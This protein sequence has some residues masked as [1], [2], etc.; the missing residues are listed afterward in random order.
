MSPDKRPGISPGISPG[1]SS[2]REIDFALYPG[3]GVRLAP[4]ARNR[5]GYPTSQLQKGLVLIANGEDLAEESV[6]FGAP[7]LKLGL[8]TIFPGAI[9]LVDWKEGQEATVVYRLNLE[10]KLARRNRGWVGN[11]LL[12]RIKERLEDAYRRIPHLRGGLMA[13]SNGLRGSFGWQTAYIDAGCDYPVTVRYAVGAQAGG[14][15][16]EIDAS[17][18]RQAGVTEVVVMNE[19]GAHHFDAYA[20]ASGRRLQGD[21]IGGWEEVRA[22]RASFWSTRCRLAFSLRQVPAARLFY[23]RE[24]VRD[25]LAWAGFGYSFSPASGGIAYTLEVERLP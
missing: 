22:R 24:L 23:G 11:P 17:E 13:L 15:S 1:N 9:A 8:R 20:D 12:Y 5:P 16:M 19:Q 21:A 18:L 14:I 10:G 6:G 3:V 7:V 4:A 2:A 25:R